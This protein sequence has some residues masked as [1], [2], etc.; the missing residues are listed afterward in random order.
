MR[1]KFT[2]LLLVAAAV[3]PA[4]VDEGALDRIAAD[5]VGNGLAI[6]GVVARADEQRLRQ[7]GQQ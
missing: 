4:S 3:L 6:A 1:T 2:I 5:P 7:A